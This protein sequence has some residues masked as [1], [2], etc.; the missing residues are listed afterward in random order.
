MAISLDL[1]HDV[2]SQMNIFKEKNYFFYIPIII[3]TV[4]GHIYV[5]HIDSKPAHKN[6][7]EKTQTKMKNIANFWDRFLP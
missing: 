1:Y 5:L 7:E 4:L 3:K 2:F 6:E